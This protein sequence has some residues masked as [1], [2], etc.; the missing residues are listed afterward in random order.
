MTDDFITESSKRRM[1][2]IRVNADTPHI[3]ELVT[4]VNA[5]GLG[6][7]GG[8]HGHDWLPT[9]LMMNSPLA[10]LSSSTNKKRMTRFRVNN[11]GAFARHLA[12]QI[13]SEGNNHNLIDPNESLSS[14]TSDPVSPQLELQRKLDEAKAIRD[15]PTFS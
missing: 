15:R 14:P 3:L 12:A 4:E 8:L 9:F 5:G 10:I 2:G 6:C 7:G 13:D 1:W 11:R